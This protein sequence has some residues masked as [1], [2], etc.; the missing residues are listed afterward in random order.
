M[1]AAAPGRVK[2]TAARFSLSWVAAVDLLAPGRVYWA[3]AKRRRQRGSIFV[4]PGGTM[5]LRPEF[6]LE[7]GGGPELGVP[8]FRYPPS[9][10]LARTPTT[11][12]R[13]E[14][15]SRELGIDIEVKRDDLTGVALTGNKVRKLEFLLAAAHDA[16]CDTV[17]T[18]GSLESNHARA[19]AVAAVKL[20]LACHLV[21]RSDGRRAPEGNHFLGRLVGATARYVSERDWGRHDEIM[22]EE[23][24]RLASEE[25]RRSYVIPVGGSNA[26]GAF[27]Y[28]RSAE[29]I[30][31]VEKRRGRSFDIVVCATGTAGTQ[32]GLLAGKVL[33]NRPWRVLGIA[34]SNRASYCRAVVEEIL[35]D[36]TTHYGLYLPG[37]EDAF[38][39]VDSYIGGG[40]GQSGPEVMATICEVAK[41]EA[42]LLDPVYTGKAFYGL[43]SEARAGRIPH[44]A[45]VLFLHTGGLPT[46]LA[47]APQ[48]ELAP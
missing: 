9:V 15:V 30:A 7:S 4:P 24:E 40:Y 5:G 10:P 17:I 21:L 27:G 39:C 48:F 8:S 6:R 32:A 42:L 33:F 14:V 41:A 18:C 46:L 3:F 20:G 37:A 28:I 45:R 22:H 44:G 26:L 13:L 36:L 34:V 11:I 35:L 47:R 16:R 12:E 29:E 25:G 43:L 38:E 2:R 19:T 23:A 31:L 1:L